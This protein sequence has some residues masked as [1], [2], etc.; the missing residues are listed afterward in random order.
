MGAD[1]VI[2][3]KDPEFQNQINKIVIPLNFTTDVILEINS[4]SVFLNKD[5]SLFFH[6]QNLKN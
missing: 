6:L 4:D 2:R 1:L 5:M 3:P